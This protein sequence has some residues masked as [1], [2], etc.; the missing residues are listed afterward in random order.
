MGMPRRQFHNTIAA[1]LRDTRGRG[2]DDHPIRNSLVART[3]KPPL[4]SDLYHAELTA[5]IAQLLPCI[6][7]AF[8]TSINRIC[9]SLAI[10]GGDIGMKADAWYID[11]SLLS[12]LQYGG[13]FSNADLCVIDLYLRHDADLMTWPCEE[14]KSSRCFLANLAH[15]PKIVQVFIF[16]YMTA[17][18]ILCERWL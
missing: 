3:M 9:R 14:Q 7:Y 16:F 4:P 15:F 5:F 1:K 17:A 8:A 6:F 2:A 13:A 12:C 11:P 10:D 18:M